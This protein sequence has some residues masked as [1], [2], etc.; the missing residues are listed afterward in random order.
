MRLV[1]FFQGGVI[2]MGVYARSQIEGKVLKERSRFF[3]HCL[4]HFMGDLDMDRTFGQ[5]L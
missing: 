3:R 5:I 2:E 1:G 4:E